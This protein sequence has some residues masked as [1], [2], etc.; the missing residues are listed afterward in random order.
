MAN[1]VKQQ[2]QARL[3]VAQAWYDS[4]E[5]RE[6]LVLKVLAA[7]VALMLVFSLF[8]MPVWSWRSDAMR[9]YERQAQLLAWIEAN[10]PVLAKR[11]SGNARPS[12]SGDWTTAVSRSVSDAGLSLKSMTPEGGDALRIQLEGQPFAETLG[13]LQGI[14]VQ[15]GATVAN[16]EIT[17]ASKPGLINFRATLRR[18][19]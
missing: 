3:Q 4:R 8:W 1:D 9:D 14:Q 15:M 13:W 5:P 2:L 10:E 17:P 12:F 19:A 6:R 18:G 11:M 16:L 7:V